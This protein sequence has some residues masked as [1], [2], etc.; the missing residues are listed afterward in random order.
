MHRA[1]PFVALLAL[2]LC[3]APSVAAEAT[4]GGLCEETNCEAD[5]TLRVVEY[6]G[7]DWCEPCRPVEAMLDG[8]ERT[9]V[10]VVRHAP[11]P[12]DG[13]FS[14]RSYQRFNGHYGLISLPAIVIDGYAVLTGETMT[15]RLEEALNATV[16]PPMNHTGNTTTWS[17]P[18]HAPNRSGTH[19]ANVTSTLPGS[20]NGTWTVVLHD[21]SPLRPLQAALQAPDT[22]EPAITE[23]LSGGEI[24][25]LTVALVV[26]CAPATV[27]LWRSMTPNQPVH[28]DEE[29]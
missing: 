23:P 27:M 2:M 16:E 26:L 8:L 20:T 25:L 15:L 21:P 10:L 29:A 18:V 13:E 7:A 3:S 19:D 17:S 24:T 14:N 12:Q 9:D 28:V 6:F 5:T 1:L 4:V 22:S 11:S